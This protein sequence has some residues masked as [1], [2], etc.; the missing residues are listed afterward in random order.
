MFAKRLKRLREEK[1]DTQAEFCTAITGAPNQSTVAGW[2][3]GGR[4]PSINV[5]CKIADYFNVTLDYLVGREAGGSLT[6]I[7][8]DLEKRVAALEGKA[9]EQP[10]VQK[11]VPEDSDHGKIQSHKPCAN[12]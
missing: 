12:P 7:V 4:E 2:E 3:A 1:G 6:D 8:A 11:F 5:L 10:V 9:Q